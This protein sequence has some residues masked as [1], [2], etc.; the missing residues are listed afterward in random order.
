[1]IVGRE[2]E[3]QRLNKVYLSNESEFIKAIFPEF[4][5]KQHTAAAVH[6]WRCFH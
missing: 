3:K 4:L 5:H 6:Q 2:R 1:M